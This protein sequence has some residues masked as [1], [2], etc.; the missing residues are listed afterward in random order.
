MNVRCG[1]VSAVGILFNPLEGAWAFHGASA[2]DRRV[3]AMA[4]RN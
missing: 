4:G 1:A 3:A 2:A